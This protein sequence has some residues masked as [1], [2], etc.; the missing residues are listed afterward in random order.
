MAAIVLPTTSSSV[1]A[2]S[3]SLP[4]RMNVR[5]RRR[6]RGA[7]EQ[8]QQEKHKSKPTRWLNDYVSMPVDDIESDDDD[9]QKDVSNSSSAADNDDWVVV[10]D[11]KAYTDGD[12][13][14][15]PANGMNTDTTLDHEDHGASTDCTNNTCELPDPELIALLDEQ[16]W[17]ERDQDIEKRIK[18]LLAYLHEIRQRLYDGGLTDIPMDCEIYELNRRGVQGICHTLHGEME[19]TSPTDRVYQDSSTH[20]IFVKIQHEF[21]RDRTYNAATIISVFL[22]QIAHALT[23]ARLTLQS[24][25]A[26]TAE[27][28]DDAQT[29]QH[30]KSSR[31]MKRRGKRRQKRK[32]WILVQHGDDFYRNY[33][34][35]LQLAAKL[36]IFALPKAP[37]Q[38]SRKKL[39]RMD[40]CDHEYLYMEDACAKIFT[41][42]LEVEMTGKI[43]GSDDEST[44]EADKVTN[45][46][47]KEHVHMDV[48]APLAR[49]MKH[50]NADC[51]SG[52]PLRAQCVT[53][54]G[55][56]TVLFQSRCLKTAQKTLRQKF[57]LK[58]VT[59]ITARV[60]NVLY[61]VEEDI[62]MATLPNGVTLNVEAASKKK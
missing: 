39:A 50:A 24:F 2:D 28:D 37:N 36:D 21:K 19:Q 11:V 4:Q 54:R 52:A 26:E 13:I 53:L 56:K 35:V 14:K 51:R 40:E 5:Q 55:T 16:P 48:I 18:L 8:P 57:R 6:R 47:V 58:K 46:D 10:D 30:T 43:F 60:D 38:Y 49:D 62:D 20:A 44:W 34:K 31:R 25:D 9:A 17:C 42:R 27:D 45:E 7:N 33:S 3:E 12:D 59:A 61:R 23:P 41:R 32:Q 15:H 22:H 29:H 1:A